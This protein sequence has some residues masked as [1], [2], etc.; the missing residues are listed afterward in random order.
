MDSLLNFIQKTEIKNKY[1]LL[2]GSSE[3]ADS[4]NN[5]NNI[6]LSGIAMS[7]K[8]NLVQSIYEASYFDISIKKQLKHII[9]GDKEI[10][11]YFKHT[12][13]ASLP[14]KE[15][16]SNIWK[17]LVH[18]TEYDK[19]KINIA[20]MN[21]FARRSQYSLLRSYLKEKFF[22]DFDIVR[23]K[24]SVEY[25][26]KFFESLNPS[27]IIE[28]SILEKMNNLKNKLTLN[29]FKLLKIVDKSK[30]LFYFI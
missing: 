8:K 9:L 12:L 10:D 22:E 11:K 16:K 6:D 3:I 7:T 19:S 20:Y 27:F 21:G 5:Y 4:K 25:S 13:E 2:R 23:N 14:D 18:N 1:S 26:L 17:H 24:H 28:D 30:F 29:D 15:K